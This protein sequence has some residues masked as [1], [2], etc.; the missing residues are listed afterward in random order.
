MQHEH[1]LGMCCCVVM[2]QQFRCLLLFP[3][4]YFTSITKWKGCC[5]QTCCPMLSLHQ[6]SCCFFCQGWQTFPCYPS[7][8]K[9]FYMVQLKLSVSPC[10]HHLH[11]DPPQHFVLQ[12]G[13]LHFSFPFDTMQALDGSGLFLLICLQCLSHPCFHSYQDITQAWELKTISEC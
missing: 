7:T 11:V 13:V 10:I 4:T 3:C 2:C 6:S 1:Q 8:S 5:S 9:P 12:M